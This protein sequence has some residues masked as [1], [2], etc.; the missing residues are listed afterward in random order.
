MTTG[1]NLLQLK[2]PQLI[3]DECYF[4]EEKDLRV[5]DSDGS[6][7]SLS[8]LSTSGDVESETESIKKP[9]F[10]HNRIF[11]GIFEKMKLLHVSSDASLKALDEFMEA[12]DLSDA[13]KNGYLNPSTQ[14]QPWKRHPKYAAFCQGQINLR[15]QLDGLAVRITPRK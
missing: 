10:R 5:P 9:E 11:D 7:L 2:L 1:L 13:P 15:E 3:L 12:E 14:F 8:E 6:L 4:V